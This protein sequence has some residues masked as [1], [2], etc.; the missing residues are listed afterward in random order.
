MTEHKVIKAYVDK[1]TK[2]LHPE[3]DTVKLSK[4]R[5]EELAAGGYIE[6]MDPAKQKEPKEKK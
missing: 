6:K 5:A 2:E 3:G 4:E 1:H